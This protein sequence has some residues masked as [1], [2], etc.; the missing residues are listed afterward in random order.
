MFTVEPSWR[1]LAGSICCINLTTYHLSHFVWRCMV[2]WFTNDA[3]PHIDGKA[4]L[5]FTSNSSIWIIMIQYTGILGTVVFIVVKMDLISKQNVTKYLWIN[6]NVIT[7]FQSATCV[8]TF[9]M[10]NVLVM[11]QIQ[12][13]M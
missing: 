13:C 4:V 3:T 2:Q 7:K 5:V 6:I 11:V 8:R 10:M 12:F 9:Q 1:G